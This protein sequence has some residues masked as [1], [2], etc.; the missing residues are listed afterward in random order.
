[1]TAVAKQIGNAVPPLLAQVIARQLARSLD[2][3]ARASSKPALALA[4]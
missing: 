4:A 1:M 3:A 2:R